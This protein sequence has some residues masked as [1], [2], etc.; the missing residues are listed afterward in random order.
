MTD[1]CEHCRGLRGCHELV[2][3]EVVLQKI[4]PTTCGYISR[5]TTEEFWRKI[6]CEFCDPQKEK[7]GTKLEVDRRWQG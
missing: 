5:E 3:K 1:V 7:Y 2:K 6:E 4:I